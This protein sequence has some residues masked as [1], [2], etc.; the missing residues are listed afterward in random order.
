[1]SSRRF[2]PSVLDTCGHCAEMISIAA[3]LSPVARWRTT[4]CAMPSKD[5]DRCTV[6]PH[7]I[8]GMPQ[9]FR[10]GYSHEAP[11]G[12]DK[13]DTVICRRWLRPLWREY[14]HPAIVSTIM[15]THYP[16]DLRSSPGT[17]AFRCTPFS[18]V[19]D[20]LTLWL[21]LGLRR[22]WECVNGPDGARPECGG[23]FSIGERGPPHSDS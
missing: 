9:R 12:I 6:L 13:I 3:W 10:R 23:P 15:R 1:M 14:L 18:D 2:R 5:P 7:A 20:S 11:P 16:R 21:A 17:A 22:C 19:L 4:D 8:S